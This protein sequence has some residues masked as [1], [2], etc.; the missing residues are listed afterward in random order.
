MSIVAQKPKLFSSPNL[1][2]FLTLA[3][4][5]LLGLGL[6]LWHLESKPLWLDEVLTALFGSG[7]SYD[8]IP[9]EQPFAITTLPRLLQWRPATCPE[10]ANNLV[11]Q[12]SHPPLFFCGLHGWLS[13]ITGVK[14][15]FIWQLR[16]LPALLGTL[17]VGCSYLLNRVA[18]N[19][20]MGLLAALL[21]A[22]SPFGVYLSQEARHYTLP[23]CIIL[24]ALTA[25]VKL[26][27][28][29]AQTQRLSLL[30]LGFWVAING[31]GLY[32]HYFFLYTFIAQ[33][34]SLGLCCLWQARQGKNGLKPVL[35]SCLATLMV[36]GIY[37]P[38]LI[39]MFRLPDQ[40]NN[41]WL[42]FRPETW[43]DGLGPLLRQ[44]AALITMVMVVPLE[45]QPAGLIIA[46]IIP[47]LILLGLLLR[48]CAAGL[49]Q[50]WQSPQR[51]SVGII[52]SFT[53]L[54]LLA[55]LASTYLLRRDVTLGFRY[56]FTILPGVIAL[57]AA[58][59]GQQAFQSKK[60]WRP[61]LAVAIGLCGTVLVVHNL[62]FLKPFS[63]ERASNKIL[64]PVPGQPMPML[65]TMVYDSPMRTAVGLSY[66]LE[67]LRRPQPKPEIS[68]AFVNQ[69][70]PA[71]ELLQQIRQQIAAMPTPLT[72]WLSG[73]KE[74]NL[75][76]VTDATI[77]A[78]VKAQGCQPEPKY[79]F[80]AN[81]GVEFHLYRCGQD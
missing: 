74:L 31:V 8:V 9:K 56:S 29:L 24:L 35:L 80:L 77:V 47:G 13:W 21:A 22:V 43:V 14:A 60:A 68:F 63:P 55:N 50:L 66:G 10:I 76:H 57:F 72:L 67:L 53:L 3:A 48:W 52:A 46:T 37:T 38:G 1:Q 16:S 20:K 81:Q 49:G 70:R 69:N 73:S 65:V 51:L 54:T 27:Q 4:I 7:L 45:K 26:G 44:A 2:H 32:A 28:Q 78:G 23:L 5:L 30:W 75:P 15:S 61:W 33:V 62:A 12:S 71:P 11:R 40:A 34:L 39:T 64:A 41:Q 42:V 17:A 19:P 59:L 25:L 79:D 6:R 18:F 36:V 58:G